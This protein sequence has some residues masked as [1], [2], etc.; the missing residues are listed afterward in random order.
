MFRRLLSFLA[1]LGKRPVA[2]VPPAG[3]AQP[4]PVSAPRL[5]VV[6]DL[7]TNFVMIEKMLQS[8]GL[9][10]TM[11]TSGSEALAAMAAQP[12]DVVLTDCRMPGMT[13]Y[14]LARAI[15]GREPGAR[16]T[17]I[18]GISANDSEADIADCL[19]SGMDDFLAKPAS[20]DALRRVL[21]K[22]FQDLKVPA[23]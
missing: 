19:A 1:V 7:P 10:A 11:V 3:N 12:F 18:I 23:Q 4:Q 15:R 22:W 8:L 16:R 21:Q 9:G 5:L 14:E 13:G 6:D 20:A 2:S 17:V